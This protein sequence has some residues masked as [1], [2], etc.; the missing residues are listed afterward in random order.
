MKPTALLSTLLLMV[1]AS[2]AAASEKTTTAKTATKLDVRE[3]EVPWEHTRPRDPDV[4]PDGKVWFVGQTGNYVGVLDPEKGSFRRIALPENAMPHNIVAGPDGAMWYAGN[5]DAHIGRIAPKTEK[6][7]KFPMPDKRAKDPHTLIFADDGT[8]WFTV[9][10]GN[11]IGRLDPKSGKVTLLEPSV[12]ASRPY[13]IVTDGNRPWAV[14]FG[15]NR[16]ATVDPKTNRLKEYTLP[17]RDARPRRLALTDDGKVWYVDYARGTLGRL[18]PDSGKVNEWK[19][20]GG[21]GSRPYAMT[22]DDSDRLWF[23]ETGSQPNRLVGFDPKKESFAHVTPIPSGG[24]TVRH[25]IYHAPQKAIWF[26]TDANTIGR[27]TVP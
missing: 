6:V 15:T 8:L 11:F 25:M 14:L 13:G 12:K 1:V 16:I 27:A 21:S 24:G 9:Q 5:G 17:A 23:V 2:P 18:A 22:V 19:T 7:T 4:A 20:P 3:W 10:H 26:G